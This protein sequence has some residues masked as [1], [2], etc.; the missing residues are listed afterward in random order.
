MPL[1]SLITPPAAAAL[2]GL[3]F[4]LPPSAIVAT[5]SALALVGAVLAAV[6]HAEVIAHRIGE[7]FGTLVLALAVTL[8]ELA[9]ILSL[10]LA[11]GASQ[12]ALPRDTIFATLMIV[13]NGIVGLCLVVGGLRHHEQAFSA[14]GTNAF[15]ATLIAMST[16][17]L[18]LP[19]FTTSSPGPTYT[20]AQ[21]GFAAVMSLLLWSV[22]VLVQ[23]GR[24]RDYFLPVGA[25]GASAD[26]QQHAPPPSTRESVASLVLLLLA[27]VA[28]VGLAKRLSPGI[29]AGLEAIGAP[30]AVLAVAI[31]IL[32][33]LPETLAAVRAARA[34]R[35]QTSF[36]LAYGSG[37]ASIGLTIPAVAAASVALGL[38]LVLGIEA[39]DL[40]LL[41]VTFLVS[42]VTL[43]S[44]RSH[45]MLGTV[46]LV[47]FAAFLFLA[48]VP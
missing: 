17:T 44:G 48:L 47:I 27:L 40:V 31:A 41:G 13:C 2:L 3:S 39:K 35:L 29:K 5:L 1:W 34:N 25:E 11:G 24:H 12:A 38:P 21:L 37:L 8:I 46:H 45:V 10:M 23:T 22:F 9:L 42:A 26:L 4:A 6:H 19:A 43:A 30:A 15:L 18:V 7:P 32:V 14:A 33:L 20:P 36:N 28:V 16:L